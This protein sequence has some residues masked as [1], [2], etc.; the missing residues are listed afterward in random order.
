[1]WLLKPGPLAPMR[2]TNKTRH[3]IE[4]NGL[5][6]VR[7]VVGLRWWFTSSPFLSYPGATGCSGGQ[8]TT[9]S[10]TQGAS[11]CNLSPYTKIST[12][13]SYTHTYMLSKSVQ[14]S[15]N[16]SYISKRVNTFPQP[17]S[18]FFTDHPS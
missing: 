16:T 7:F 2:Q 15:L 8:A 10:C 1:M 13:P 14:M 4:A 6:Q 5:G 18:T 11:F 12:M 9:Y 17:F 3:H